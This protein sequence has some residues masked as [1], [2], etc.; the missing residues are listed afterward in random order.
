MAISLGL[1]DGAD[2]LWEF[3]EHFAPV[4]G[5]SILHELEGLLSEGGHVTLAGSVVLGE[6]ELSGEFA[7]SLSFRDIIGDVVD[8]LEHLS[9]IWGTRSGLGHDVLSIHDHVL[10][11]LDAAHDVVL[12]ETRHLAVR[13]SLLNVSLDGLNI[14]KKLSEVGLSRLDLGE[15]ILDFVSKVSN[16]L[17]AGGEVTSLDLDWSG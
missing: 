12:T 6:S 8:I 17:D 15:D 14:S 10:N 13:F 11:L 2:H 3:L 5:S 9:E 16:V 7:V 1:L 4:S